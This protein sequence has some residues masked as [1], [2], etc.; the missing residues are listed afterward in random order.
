MN[1]SVLVTGATGFA[2]SHLVDL[3]VREHSTVIGWHRP[4]SERPPDTSSARWM[5]V[6]ILDELAVRHAIADIRPTVAYHCAGVP[7]TAESWRAAATT[8]ETN[9]L[10]THNLLTAIIAAH[11]TTRVLVPGSAL[12]YRPSDQPLAE[13]STIGPQS[14]YGTS[15]LAQ[16]LLAA[17]VAREDALPVFLTR[18]FNHLGPR[19]D[20]SFAASS[21]A[22]QVARIE[23]RLDEPV[24]RVGNLEARRDLTD[25]RDVVHA[26]WAIVERG[27]PGKV[28]N[29]CSERAY[30][31][32]EILQR[33]VVLARVRV[34]IQTDAARL[35]PNDVPLLL[36]SAHRIREEVGWTPAVPIDRTLGD[37]LDYWRGRTHA[38]TA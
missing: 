38:E 35:R 37:L 15:K 32:S 5:T 36:G 24:I 17:S 18:S 27:R 2:G 8:L 25:V 10:G 30:A 29:V 3:L 28:Y 13:D 14:P 22:R 33:L 31:I 19:Q 12:V 20:P 26:Y 23:A 6:D 9:V 21:F 1:E 11:L 16:E 7:H 4:G 34:D